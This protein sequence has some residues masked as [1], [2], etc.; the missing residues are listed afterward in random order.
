VSDLIFTIL[1]RDQGSKALDDVGAAS[2]RARERLDQFGNTG[3]KTLAKMAPAALGA[4]VA[5]GGMLG[6]VA[7]GFVVAGAAIVSGNAEVAQSWQDLT[8]TVADGAQDAARPLAGPLHDAL[9]DVGDAAEE[10]QP[11]L[12]EAFVEAAPYVD[13]LTDGVIGFARGAMPGFVTAVRS[14][15][16]PMRGFQSLLIDTGAGVGEMFTRVSRASESSGRILVSTGQVVRDTLGF[17]GGLLAELSDSGAPAVDQLRQTLWQ[18]YTVALQLGSGGFPVLFGSAGILLNMLEGLLALLA[19]IA[20]EVGTVLGVVLSLAAAFRL[21]SAVT[22]GVQAL[23]VALDGLGQGARNVGDGAGA[24]QGRFAGIASF[25]A[26]PLGLALGV[27]AAAYGMFAGKQSSAA[28]GAE[29][30]RAA[31]RA[32]KGEID[33]N[34]RSVAAKNLQ[35]QGS[36]DKARTLGI[37]LADLTDAYLGQGDAAKNLLPRLRDMQKELDNQKV[38]LQQNAADTQKLV[39][40]L[41]NESF[42][43][44]ELIDVLTE[45]TPANE[46]AIQEARN[47][48]EAT[49]ESSSKV[50]ELSLAQLANKAAA[51]E[52]AAAYE[53]LKTNVSDVNAR[54]EALRTILDELTGRNTSYEDAVQGINA[55][56]RGLAEGFNG[57][58]ASGKGFGS[59]LINADGTINTTKA[60]GAQLRDTLKELERNTLAGADAL[61]RNGATQ[62]EVAQFV[63]Q[64]RDRFIDQYQALGLTKDEAGR[65]ATQYGLIPQQVA[66]LISTPGLA[67]AAQRLGMFDWQVRNLPDGTVVIDAKTSAAQDGINRLIQTNDGRVISI[68]V[69]ANGDVWALGDNGQ[70]VGMAARA[71]GGPVEAGKPYLVG[72][73]G[74]EIIF[75]TRAGFVATARETAEIQAGAR[76]DSVR[77]VDPGVPGGGVVERHFHLHLD[78]VRNSDVDLIAQYQRMEALDAP[79]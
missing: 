63:Q 66:T 9:V 31:L 43:V 22:G 39:D 75:P 11:Q 18:L 46:K 57:A 21:F 34:V 3:V 37:S 8:Q 79:L 4:G 62:Q 56:L 72:E 50:G 23:G 65:L 64:T 41:N 47:L 74:P 25:V 36:I 55:T 52:Q 68:A 44:R 28:R 13:D 5:V 14:G 24:A 12:A 10:M 61:A 71:M 6:L 16:A 58:A 2:D 70:R 32:S 38:P 45:G 1:G 19:P 20:S 15:E 27:G 69:R 78:G 40:E 35:D 60:N 7:A 30:L 17:V 51:S 67:E 26:G 48:A 49:A 33:D 29:D 54:V 73:D 76:T 42:A 77:A 59:E 53:T